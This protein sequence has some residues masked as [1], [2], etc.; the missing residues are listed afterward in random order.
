MLLQCVVTNFIR[1]QH[2][3]C[4]QCK[5]VALMPANEAN[6]IR[7]GGNKIVTNKIDI[8]NHRY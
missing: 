8:I 4:D 3:C 5:W 6:V 2:Y 7:N 1:W